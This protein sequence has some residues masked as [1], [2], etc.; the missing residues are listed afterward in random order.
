MEDIAIE[1]SLLHSLSGIQ[2][3]KQLEKITQFG[4]FTLVKGETAIYSVGGEYDGDFDALLDAAHK[5]VEHGN[6]VYLLPNPRNCRTADFIF[7][8]KGAYMMY[9]LKTVYG[10]KKNAPYMMQP[11]YSNGAVS[12]KPYSPHSAA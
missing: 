3:V 11:F 5:A 8:K 4:G 10:Y 6:T 9:D 2:F 7:R 12:V 1:L